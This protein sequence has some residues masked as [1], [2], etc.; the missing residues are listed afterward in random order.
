M[1]YEAFCSLTVQLMVKSKNTNHKVKECFIISNTCLIE[2]IMLSYLNILNI[3]SIRC[4]TQC[5]QT[6][7]YFRIGHK[8]FPK[9]GCPIIF[10][11]DDD[12]TLINGQKGVCCPLL[13]G[14]KS[15]I[16]TIFSPKSIPQKIIK[17]ALLPPR[18]LLA[19]KVWMKL[20]P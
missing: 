11:H 4:K 10:Y 7:C 18:I 2:K 3:T 9:Q 12:R 16:K 17:N 14:V 20:L 8:Q 6:Q 5:L 13:C 15:I 1:N 19:Y